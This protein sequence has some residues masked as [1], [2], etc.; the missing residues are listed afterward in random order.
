MDLTTATTFKTGNKYIFVTTERERQDA[1]VFLNELY[2]CSNAKSHSHIDRYDEKLK[3]YC[4]LIQRE[5]KNW[6]EI[7][8]MNRGKYRY[9]VNGDC[10]YGFSAGSKFKFM[11]TASMKVKQ[12]LQ[13]VQHKTKCVFNMEKGNFILYASFLSWNDAVNF[14]DF[15]SSLD[16]SNYYN[17]KDVF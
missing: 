12:Y 1:G 16:L 3:K 17:Y 11:P 6:V 9:E 8:I 7:R 15:L 10:M 2:I 14:A 5:N 13:S 4:E